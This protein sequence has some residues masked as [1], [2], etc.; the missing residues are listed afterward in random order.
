VR[1]Y[2]LRLKEA[3]LL[4]STPEEILKVGTDFRYFNQ[5]QKE[6]PIA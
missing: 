1:F 4:K 3:G 5:L 6:L 2:A